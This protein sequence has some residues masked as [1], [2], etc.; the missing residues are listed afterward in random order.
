MFKKLE[1]N[2]KKYYLFALCLSVAASS[3][4]QANTDSIALPEKSTAG[5]I[6]S[7]AISAISQNYDL[8][9]FSASLYV[10]DLLSINDTIY[11]NTE[12]AGDLILFNTLDRTGF[13]RF[14]NERRINIEISERPIIHGIYDKFLYAGE[15]FIHYPMF[16]DKDQSNFI[17]IQDT[18]LKF[19]GRD[20]Y[21]ISYIAKET[22]FPNVKTFYAK[23]FYGSIYIDADNFAII[24]IEV[25]IN[26]DPKGWVDTEQNMAKGKGIPSTDFK[27]FDNNRFSEK[28]TYIFKQKENGLY[29]NVSNT[30][31]L[32]IDETD[33][34]SNK[35]YIY[36]RLIHTYIYN[37]HE[38]KKLA[39]KDYFIDWFNPDIPY[40]PEFW[41]NFVAPVGT[42][43]KELEEL[44]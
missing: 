29:Y 5:E 36:K 41:N 42:D 40:N 25:N 34:E 39:R 6:M 30:G 22:D 19:M 13:E 3:F 21:R 7:K 1:F 18:I 17:Y 4:S 9:K 8:N 2:F 38:G 26:Y 23:S 15:P 37:F 27:N 28:F 14:Y 12:Y 35:N 20:I 11:M 31:Y 32:L 43:V 44:K 33:L 10:S 16:T 24:K